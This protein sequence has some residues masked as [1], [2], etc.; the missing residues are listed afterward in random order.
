[1]NR[2]PDRGRLRSRPIDPVAATGRKQNP[3][4]F[5]KVPILSFALDAKTRRASHDQDPFVGLLIVPFPF[6]RSLARRDDALDAYVRPLEENIDDL[7]FSRPQGELAAKIP[8][9]QFCP[10]HL[11]QGFNVVTW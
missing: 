11:A 6:R 3:V 10:A 8:A 5:A 4:A 2:K 7:R 1:M 9:R